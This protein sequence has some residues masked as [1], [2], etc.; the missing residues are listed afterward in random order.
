MNRN[1][2]TATPQYP[3]PSESARDFFDGIA[4]YGTALSFIARRRLWSY[5]VVPGLISLMLGGAIFYSAWLLSG[6]VNHWLTM[7]YPADWFGASVVSSLASVASWLILAASGLLTYRV[8]LMALV[9]P[10]MS[11]LAARVQSELTGAPVFDPPFFSFT[12]FRLILRGAIL[13]LRNVLKELL[14]TV[15]LLLLCLIPLVGLVVP[16][17]IFAVQSFYA[18]FGNLDYSLEKYYGIADSKRFSE[19]HRWLAVG[20]GAAFLTLLAVPLVGLFVAPALSVVAATLEST[21]RI[22]TPL[23][24]VKQL[25][26]F[27]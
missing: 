25:E 6:S 16:F 19:R 26:Q 1:F 10:F 14:Y 18:G 5:L 22:H 11:P 21:K 7:I 27:I 2:P 23:R 17:V 13:N 4:S 8:L 3:T 12:N 9:A 20:N 15:L 24:N